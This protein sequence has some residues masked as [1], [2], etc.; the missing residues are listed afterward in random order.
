MLSLL[1]QKTVVLHLWP[2][3]ISIPCPLSCRVYANKRRKYLLELPVSTTCA[4]PV[5]H[6][7]ATATFPSPPRQA[8]RHQQQQ[9][10]EVSTQKMQDLGSRV[11]LQERG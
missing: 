10:S 4:T 3:P 1:A 9:E 8:S 6:T 7:S 5:F 11:E 2:K